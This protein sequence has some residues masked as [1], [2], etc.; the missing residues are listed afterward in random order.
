MTLRHH[1]KND[2]RP[3]RIA[4]RRGFADLVGTP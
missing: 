1:R 3:G 2:T 4:G